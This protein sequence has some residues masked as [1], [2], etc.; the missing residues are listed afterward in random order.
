MMSGK[1]LKSVVNEQHKLIKSKNVQITT[2][3]KS[4]KKKIK[5]SELRMIGEGLLKKAKKGSRLMVKVL[6]NKGYFQLKSYDEDMGAILDPDK[7]I[8]GREG[9]EAYSI[10]KASFYIL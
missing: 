10:Y 4:N 5:A 6:S 2:I 7:Y 8:N 3:A 1:F 9:I